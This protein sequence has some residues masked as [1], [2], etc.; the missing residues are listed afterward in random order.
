MIRNNMN[1][2]EN[3]ILW[4][5]SRYTDYFSLHDYHL[6]YH[7]QSSDVYCIGH[8]YDFPNEHRARYGIFCA[9]CNVY[10]DY[11]NIRDSVSSLY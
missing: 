3:I 11:N 2:L 9:E 5:C 7:E 8:R 1:K 6:T 10:S 4:S